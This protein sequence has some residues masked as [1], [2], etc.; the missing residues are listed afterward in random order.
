MNTWRALVKY[1]KAAFLWRWNLLAFGAGVVA[2]LLSGAFSVVF[3]LVAAAELV[4]L[5]LLTSQPRFRKA[6]DVRH[7][8]KSGPMV[9]QN[10]VL[11][12]IRSVLNEDAW[13]RFEML[14]DRCLALDKLGQQ[15][16]G[17]SHL[18]AEAV[19][20]LQTSSLERLLWMFLKLLYSQD[21]LDRF[22]RS[23][24]RKQ[25]DIQV[26]AAQKEL[27]VATNQGRN[28]KLLASMKDRYET[29]KQRQANYLRAVEHREFLNVEIDRIEQKVNAISEMAMSSRDPA[30]ISAQVD[31]IAEGISATEEAIR[32][33]D[34]APV[35]ER[36]EAPRL[37]SQEM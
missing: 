8:F 19:S 30:D 36:E 29:L 12:Q 3:P 4:Y 13:L 16:R 18:Q 21:A 2:S 22:L 14:R 6:V 33:M 37:L 26:A 35:F 31:G 5:G 27:D 24:D 32:Q 11:E 17:P 15:F 23:T 20:D 25:L 34:V 1:I 10:K 7:T 9:D 28:E